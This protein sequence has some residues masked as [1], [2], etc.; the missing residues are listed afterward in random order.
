M[1]K[2]DTI[3]F[4]LEL[5]G[6][7]LEDSLNLEKLASN[8]IKSVLRIFKDQTKT[9]GNKS[10]SLS[11]KN[12]IDLLFDIGELDKVKLDHLVKFMEIRNQFIHNHECNSFDDLVRINQE[13]TNY[14]I[15]NFSDGLK[16]K[17]FDLYG[18]YLKLYLTCF[19]NLYILDREYNWGIE[20]DFRKHISDKILNNFDELIEQSIERFDI[21]QK[22][23]TFAISFDTSK[24][25]IDLFVNILRME[26]KVK[27]LEELK[28]LELDHN[29][30]YKRKIDILQK[31]K[32]NG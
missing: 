23:D 10:S 13:L 25:Q 7:V 20:G 19:G 1:I 12:K 5:R 24:K 9:L 22:E 18:G 2:I 15:K 3:D 30:I 21:A 29:V 26:I 17:E 14:L 4:N 11:F 6:K 28:E 32:N 27:Q 16:G 31:M 8:V